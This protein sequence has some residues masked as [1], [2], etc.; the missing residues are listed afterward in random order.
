MFEL[1]KWSEIISDI[2]DEIKQTAIICGLHDN[3]SLEQT[4]TEE[5]PIK[6][7]GSSKTYKYT[8][9]KTQEQL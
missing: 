3:F 6:S 7:K 9:Y 1:E 8:K 2:F 4:K 5:S